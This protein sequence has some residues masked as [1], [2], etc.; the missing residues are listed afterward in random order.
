MTVVDVEYE[1]YHCPCCAGYIVVRLQYASSETGGSVSLEHHKD[2]PDYIK[3][4][5]ITD[6]VLNIEKR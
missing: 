4:G 6:K 2:V 3:K 5:V 1:L